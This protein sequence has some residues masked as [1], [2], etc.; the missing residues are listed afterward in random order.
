MAS[1]GCEDRRACVGEL[2]LNS[3]VSM[4][5]YGE[6]ICTLLHLQRGAKDLNV[7]EIK[8]NKIMK[9]QGTVS[10]DVSGSCWYYE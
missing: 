9:V 6:V 1:S 4:R 7:P 10:R 8:I 3:I 5:I 2:F